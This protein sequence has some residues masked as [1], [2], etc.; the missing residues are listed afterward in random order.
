MTRLNAICLT[1]AGFAV[2]AALAWNGRTTIAAEDGG[3]AVGQFLLKEEPKD[4]K[5][6]IDVRKDAKNGED[7]VVVGRIGGRK[8]PWVKGAAAFSIVDEAIKSCDQIHGDNCPTPWDYCC[9][10]DLP[11]KTVFVSFVDESGKI[12]KEDARKL[13][14][15]KELQTVV[16]VGKAKRDKADNVS[17]QATN[18]FVRDEKEAVIK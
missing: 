11:Q 12:V 8:N 7:V 15:L 3:K 1:L 4:A 14:K 18:V 16:V 10:E 13:L 5:A 2:V 9:E 6:V 17:I